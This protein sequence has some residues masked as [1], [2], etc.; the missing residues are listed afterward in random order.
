[1]VEFLVYEGCQIDAG[2]QTLFICIQK[3]SDHLG[4]PRI[5]V[6]SRVSTT[7]IDVISV[8]LGEYLINT[9]RFEEVLNDLKFIL[10]TVTE[11]VIYVNVFC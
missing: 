5:V 11:N 8:F 10:T 1:M 7:I 4:P 9:P 2:N 6:P 3:D